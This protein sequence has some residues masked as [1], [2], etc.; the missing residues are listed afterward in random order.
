MNNTEDIFISLHSDMKNVSSILSSYFYSLGT[1]LLLTIA[2]VIILSYD[3][4]LIGLSFG[5]LMLLSSGLYFY[6]MKKVQ[7]ADSDLCSDNT[8]SHFFKD[9]VNHIDNIKSE[10]AIQFILGKLSDSHDRLLRTQKSKNRSHVKTY[11]ISG[12]IV[13][14][15]FLFSLFAGY[16]LVHAHIVSI[17]W[18]YMLIHYTQLWIKPLYKMYRS[19]DQYGT[20]FSSLNRITAILSTTNPIQSGPL[21]LKGLSDPLSIGFYNVSFQYA[22]GKELF[23]EVDFYIHPG[24]KVVIFGKEESGKST[25]ANLM[26]RFFDCTNGEIHMNDKRIQSYSLHSLRQSIGLVSHKTH[27]FKGTIRDNITFF[28]QSI[29]DHSIYQFIERCGL[30]PWF[31]TFDNGLNTYLSSGKENVSAR[32]MNILSFIRTGIHNPRCII[33]DDFVDQFD[34][35]TKNMVNQA[36]DVLNQHSTIIVFTKQRSNHDRYDQSFILQGGTLQKNDNPSAA[37]NTNEPLLVDK[38]F[39]QT[40]NSYW[41]TLPVGSVE[42]S[43]AEHDKENTYVHQEGKLHAVT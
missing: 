40:C 33:L 11:I 17:G 6:G 28:N 31:D 30:L 21:K 7:T 20:L 1:H 37:I 8:F 25:M 43:D 10:G 22:P 4:T 2:I 38:E 36:I 5:G 15:L 26:L 32:E 41:N 14:S 12:M 9:N 27:L 34:L 29:T 19:S 13:S 18:A 3:N 39:V 24:E 23:R 16:T 35:S 42:K